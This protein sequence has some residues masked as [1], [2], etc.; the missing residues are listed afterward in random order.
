MLSEVW[1]ISTLIVLLENW[2]KK[3]VFP[4]LDVL[5]DHREEFPIKVGTRKGQTEK[6]MY[7]MLWEAFGTT[8]MLEYIYHLLTEWSYLISTLR[9]TFCICVRVTPVS[10]CVNDKNL[11][12]C[13]K[14]D[15]WLD[16]VGTISH[17]NNRK[18]SFN[19]PALTWTW[20]FY[21]FICIEVRKKQLLREVERD[22]NKTRH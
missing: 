15:P 20:Q 10:W 21:S 9:N 5:S 7:H 4:A 13:T 12:F 17:Q 14:V 6:W 2:K 11:F 18:T 3:C 22:K 19:L 1:N 16:A 8:W